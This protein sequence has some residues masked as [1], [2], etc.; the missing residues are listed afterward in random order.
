[1]PEDQSDSNDQSAEHDHAV[2]AIPDPNVKPPKFDL[3][4][5]SFDGVLAKRNVRQDT[6]KD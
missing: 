6:K 4:T 2:E 1:M 5:E 3:V